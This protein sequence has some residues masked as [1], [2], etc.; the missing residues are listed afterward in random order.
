MP[1]VSIFAIGIR[2]LYIC[3]GLVSL[4]FEY[5]EAKADSDGDAD[6]DVEARRDRLLAERRDALTRQAATPIEETLWN[7]DEPRAAKR[8]EAIELDDRPREMRFINF[9][10]DKV[11]AL[12]GLGLLACG[13]F[14]FVMLGALLVL[15]AI[16]RGWLLHYSTA[17]TGN[18]FMVGENMQRLI[19]QQAV[20]V[21][22]PSGAQPGRVRLTNPVFK[23]SVA[24]CIAD[25]PVKRGMRVKV[26]AIDCGLLKIA[27]DQTAVKSGSQ[28]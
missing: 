11:W 5:Q 14:G 24:E 4:W 2:G 6:I 20:V 13:A 8:A 12:L 26:L 9:L 21:W 17:R 28:R 22:V 1:P 19:G 15:P 23:N 3:I 10:G 7:D 18:R 27:P 25:E 16:A